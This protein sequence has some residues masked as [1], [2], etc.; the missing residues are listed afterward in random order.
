MARPTLFPPS[1]T[2]PFTCNCT[3]EQVSTSHVC[4]CRLCIISTIVLTSRVLEVDS[5]GVSGRREVEGFGSPKRIPS[6]D[7]LGSRGQRSRSDT[8]AHVTVLVPLVAS[9][10]GDWAWAVW[11]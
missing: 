1:L 2:W 5:S 7:T 11:S 10:D 4:R 9:G 3:H 8:A 6:T